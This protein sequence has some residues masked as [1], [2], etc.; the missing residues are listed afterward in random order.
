MFLMVYLFFCYFF[1]LL[2][3]LFYYYFFLLLL[4]LPLLLMILHLYLLFY[5]LHFF[6]FPFSVLFFYLFLHLNQNHYYFLLFYYFLRNFPH[7]NNQ[8][9]LL[10][11]FPLHFHM[12]MNNL[13][14]IQIL[15]QPLQSYFSILHIFFFPLLIFLDH[16]LD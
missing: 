8:K 3:E 6:Y 12:K 10:H 4:P 5:L 7:C 13:N 16:Q 2:D 1:D 14:L 9:K 11:S 15:I